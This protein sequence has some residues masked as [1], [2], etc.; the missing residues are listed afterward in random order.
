MEGEVRIQIAQEVDALVEA[1]DAARHRAVAGIDAEPS[2]APLF[3]GSRAAHRETVAQLREAGDDALADRVA[4]LRAERAQAEA[5]EAW[6]AAEWTATG[7]GPAGPAA[8]R[9]AELAVREARD[10]LERRA[11]ARAETEAIGAASRDRERAVEARARARAEVGL[12]PDWRAVVEGDGVLSASDDAWRDV[13]SFTAWRELRVRPVPAGDL[14]RAGLL[15]VIALRRWAGLFHMGMLSFELRRAFEPLRLDLGRIRVDE[16]ARDGKWPGVHR[17]GTRLS[18][19]PTKGPAG[20]LDLFSGAGAAIAASH[21]P[22]HRRDAAF[23][24]AFGWLV[25]SIAYEPR[26]LA[27]RC[28]LDRRDAPDLLRALRLRRLFRLRARAAA[29]RVATEVERGASGA[30][31]RT[32]Y[33][34]AMTAALGA[35][36]DAE[37]AARDGDADV[38]RA[39]LAGM[40]GGVALRRSMIERFDEDWWR[41]PR[42]AEALAALL[43]AGRLPPG[44]EPSPAK[45]AAAL[46]RELGDG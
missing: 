22:P 5:E 20:W 21:Q 39:A 33:R 11:W 31:W 8:L 2:L 13:L 38:H 44:E 41:N 24:R 27:D 46:A 15:R 1:L 35:A 34:D 18:F 4:W 16:P 45:A 6:R 30:A 14:D 25:G 32:G 28:R 36:W 42:S 7:I 19:R 29:L 10:F 3:R 26:F 40:A 37:R 43:A 17:F 9:D 12:A 23:E